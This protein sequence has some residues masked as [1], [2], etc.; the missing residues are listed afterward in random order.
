MLPNLQ[1]KKI[2]EERGVGEFMLT[3]VASGKKY[4]C[5]FEKDTHSHTA[6]RTIQYVPDVLY[7]SLGPSNFGSACW[8]C[9]PACGTLS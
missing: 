8:V 3:D 9:R 7:G 5:R 2:L 6:S 4:D 1:D